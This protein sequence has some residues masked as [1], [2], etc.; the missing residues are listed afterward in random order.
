MSDVANEPL[1]PPGP[2]LSKRVAIVAD[3]R[4]ALL[5]P[6]RQDYDVV[7][8]A[9]YAGFVE[10]CDWWVIADETRYVECCTWDRPADQ[11]RLCL[12]ASVPDAV[13]NADD[14]AVSAAWERDRPR[15]VFKEQLHE[16]VY[17]HV[18]QPVRR[19]KWYRYSGTTALGLAYW[20]GAKRIDCYGMNLGLEDSVYS[21][22]TERVSTPYRWSNEAKIWR[23]LC[24]GLEAAGVEIRQA[25]LVPWSVQRERASHLEE[26]G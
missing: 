2:L 16:T 18:V 17:P 8:A 10:E 25:D 20:L 26:A 7:I 14:E 24:T 4:S 12:R 13:R 23:S 19:S 21:G 5:Y 3:G 6:G 9:M 1:P 11:R 15:T 22:P